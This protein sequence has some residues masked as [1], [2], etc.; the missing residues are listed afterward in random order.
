MSDSFKVLTDFVLEQVKLR[1]SDTENSE[2]SL[3]KSI[4]PEV[5]R[6][7]IDFNIPAEG[8]EEKRLTEIL[9]KIIEYSV[10]TNHPYFMN[11]MFGKTQPIAFLADILISVLNTSM[12]TYEVAP[13]L[14]LIEKETIGFLGSK[15]WGEETGGGVFTSGGSMSNMKAMFLA[16]Q[17]KFNLSKKEGLTHEK[18]VAVFISEQAHYSFTK[19]VNFLGFG[20]DALIKVPTLDNAKI[21]IV[22]LKKVIEKAKNEGRIPLMMV[23][24]AGT[25]I[26][27]TF[28]PI[29]ELAEIAQENNMWFHVDA[30]FGGALLFSEQEKHKLKGIERADSVTWNFHKVMGMPLSTSSFLTKEKGVLKRAF[31]VDAAYLFHQDDDDMDLGQKSLQGGRRPEVLK[32]WLSLKYEGEKGFANR[33]EKLRKHAQ[34]LTEIVLQTPNFELYQQPESAIVCFR[35]VLENA[36]LQENNDFNI[37]L[38]ES[39][40]EEGKILFNYAPLHD[41]IYLRC[42]LLDPDF[43]NSQLQEIVDAILAKA[44]IFKSK[45]EV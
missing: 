4:E 11:Q 5:L 31:Q 22:A 37:K 9:H 16:R 7:L 29:E 17:R 32:L 45:V 44:V 18:P 26:S 30:A 41:K 14:S 13:V 42:V 34:T 24:I 35:Y 25:T 2:I 6:Q 15:I 39:I 33:I 12:Y 3:R 20:T 43:T 10:K 28:D 38:R 23:A 36:T 40:F 8:I 27:G 19:G 1:L 21:D